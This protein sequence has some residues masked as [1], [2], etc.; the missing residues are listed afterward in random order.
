MSRRGCSYCIKPIIL[1]FLENCL[2]WVNFLHQTC[3]GIEWWRI[4]RHM[5]AS[6]LAP[7][8]WAPSQGPQLNL[9]KAGDDERSLEGYLKLTQARGRSQERGAGGEWVNLLHTA[10]L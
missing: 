6:R 8:S 9:H 2:D 4:V 1:V 5:S 10:D 7:P 3:I